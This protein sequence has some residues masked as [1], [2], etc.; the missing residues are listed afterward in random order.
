MVPSAHHASASNLPLTSAGL[1]TPERGSREQPRQWAVVLLLVWSLA[2]L[3]TGHFLKRGWVPHDEGMLAQ[4]ATRFLSGEL[5]HRDFDEPYTGGLTFLNA[6]ALRTFGMTLAGPRWMLYLAFL[7]WVPVFYFLAASVLPKPLWAGGLTLLAV[8]W[9]VPNYS[10]ALPS[11]YNLFFA[12][13]GTACALRFQINGRRRWLVA[14][15]CCGGLS[16]LAKIVGLYFVSALILFLLYYEQDLDRVPTTL[17]SVAA[18]ASTGSGKQTRAYRYFLWAGLALFVLAL[19]G[20]L[21]RHAN[22][23]A[24]VHF[25][26]PGAGLAALLIRRELRGG[27][28]DARARFRALS[29]LLSP[30]LLGMALPLLA[31][32]LV[33]LHAHAFSALLTGLFVLPFKRLQFAAFPPP[34]LKT[35]LLALP[36]LGLALIAMR[37]PY[38]AS[39]RACG[40]LGLA[41]AAILVLAH[42]SGVAY[43]LAWYPLT[44]LAPAVIVVGV[45][46]LW[47]E[48]SPA[49][50]A[51]RQRL[52][53]LLGVAAL[54][55]LVEFPFA[56]PIYFCFAF[57]L[58][59]LAAASLVAAYP[60]LR[61]TPSAGTAAGFVPALL[62]VFYL[63]FAVWRFTPGG[64]IAYGHAAIPAQP[65]TVLRLP[66]AGGLRVSSLDADVYERLIGLVQEHAQG[67]FIY[68]APDCPEVYFLSGRRN[69]TR[70]LFDF[71]DSEAGRSTRILRALQQHDVRVVVINTHPPFSAALDAAL[72]AALVSQFP[73]AQ[74]VG[75]FTVRWRS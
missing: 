61:G 43:R 40:L 14:A 65:S 32:V 35:W 53:L 47:R 27:F 68:A 41:L 52:L 48:D 60:A 44:L 42:Q 16:I 45:A 18:P 58:T 46:A 23:I 67:P 31:F 34:P 13:W 39:R 75:P 66:R 30:L 57:P 62:L 17:P 69:P 50:V 19:A 59:F 4:S 9:S 63:V 1:A 15:G 2:A 55:S 38:A 72:G 7:G 51:S 36:I 8:V 54:C 10:A 25:L 71:F 37:A 64:L 49:E 20:L 5:P 3:Y 28:D 74:Q 70:T 22:F 29:G 56:A 21:R 33:Y 26:V 11:W 24:A 6:A 73:T 12:T